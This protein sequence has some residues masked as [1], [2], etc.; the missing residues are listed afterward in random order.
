MA[1]HL[2]SL[3]ASDGDFGDAF[4]YF[5]RSVFAYGDH[6][7]T[8]ASEQM[9]ASLV[10]RNRTAWSRDWDDLWSIVDME[11]L[12]AEDSAGRYYELLKRLEELRTRYF[13]ELFVQESTYY[14][15]RFPGSPFEADVLYRLGR[16]AISLELEEQAVAS[17]ASVLYVYPDSSV[18]FQAVRD[19]GSY[20]QDA[21]GQPE[22]ALGIYEF[23]LGEPNPDAGSE[24]LAARRDALERRAN[25]LEGD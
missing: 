10:H 19:L 21:L 12:G 1:F 9:L 23:A 6:D 22:F 14:L 18:Y 7:Y 24:E 8:R 11:S 17:L 3:I 15:R 16:R 2:G 4:A 5:L 25:L 13:R 20:Y